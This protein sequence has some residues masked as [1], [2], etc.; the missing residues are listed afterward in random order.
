MEVHRW[1]TKVEGT[2]TRWPSCV[3][4]LFSSSPRSQLELSSCSSSDSSV[5]EKSGVKSS[6]KPPP[7][8]AA[9]EVDNKNYHQLISS[10][11]DV[12][13]AFTAP[14]CGHCK[15]LKPVYEKVATAF[16]NEKNVVVAQMNADADENKE[17]ASEVGVQGFPT[18]KF[19]PKDGSGPVNYA[20]ARSEEA[21]VEVSLGA[22]GYT[23]PQK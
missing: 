15:S 20:S 9:L 11:K 23:P 22:R 19:F 21:F 3:Y 10:G 18:I 2:S 7:P 17:I 14:W 13:I 12:L 8:P 6:I 4:N 1:I 16:K 5:T